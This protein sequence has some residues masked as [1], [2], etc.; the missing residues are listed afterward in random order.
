MPNNFFNGFQ[1]QQANAIF[2]VPVQGESGARNYPVAA[3]NTVLLIDFDTGKFW[4]KSTD[5]NCF[6]SRFTAYSFKEDKTNQITPTNGNFV[7]KTEF[8]NLKA[9]LDNQ[10][11]KV[12]SQ[13][14]TLLTTEGKNHVGAINRADSESS[15]IP[16]EV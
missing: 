13:L 11:Q 7:S 9:N 16:T 8:E 5:T 10:F 15:T 12:I 4:L 2:A 3:G 1:Q 6:P 14:Q